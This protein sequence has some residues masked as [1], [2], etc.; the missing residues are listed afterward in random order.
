MIVI[1]AYRLTSK[2][3]ASRIVG[4]LERELRG[5]KLPA[6][7]DHAKGREG[8]PTNIGH[9]MSDRGNSRIE[10]ARL[11]DYEVGHRRGSLNAA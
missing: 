2:D 6:S 9:C 7:K 3:P 1:A 11:I 5:V 8:P 4:I 10:R